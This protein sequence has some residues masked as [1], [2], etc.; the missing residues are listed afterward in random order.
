MDSFYNKD[1]LKELGLKSY[2]NKVLISRKVSLYSPHLISLGNNVRIDDFCI[3]SGNIEIGSHI[4]ISAYTA[5]YG[6]Q[7][8]V[9]E[10]YSGISPRCTVFS[11]MDDFSGNYLIG[12]IHEKNKIHTVGGIVKLERYSQIGANTVVFP[13]V[14]IGQGTVV[15]AMSLVNSSLDSWGIYVGIPVRRLKDRRR[16]LLNL[17]DNDL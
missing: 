17:I 1:E 16:D 11:M 13:N 8:I 5:L 15:G 2:G 4:H 14:I 6:S 9:L 3:L 12:P 7:G 10:D